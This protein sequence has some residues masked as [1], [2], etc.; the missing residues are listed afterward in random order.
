MVLTGVLTSVTSLLGREIL[1]KVRFDFGQT[2]SI[3]QR[4]QSLRYD[5]LLDAA[6]LIGGNPSFKANVSL[7]DPATVY[8]AISDIALLTRADKLIVTDAHGRLLAW[9]GDEQ[10]FGEERPHTGIPELWNTDGW[11]AYAAIVAHPRTQHRWHQRHGR[12][13]SCAGRRRLCANWTDGLDTVKGMGAADAD[14][15]DIGIGERV[16]RNST[17]H[18]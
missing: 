4:A 9:Y 1:E 8:Q 16:A 2:E 5:S 3:F 13:L 12:G 11:K 15:V 14:R 7:D 6:S 18:G 17:R 10:R